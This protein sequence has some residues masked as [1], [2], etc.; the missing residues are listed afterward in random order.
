MSDF[1]GAVR[2]YEREIPGALPLQWHFFQTIESTRWLPH[3]LERGLTDEPLAAIDGAGTKQFREWPVGQY[4]FRIAKGTDADAQRL[5]ATAVGKVAQSKHPDGRHQGLD[6]IANHFG[7]SAPDDYTHMTPHPLSNSQMAT[8]SI[9]DALVI[10]VRDAALAVCAKDA[11]DVVGAVNLLR[12]FPAKIFTRISM[13]VLSKHANAAPELS[14]ALLLDTNLIGESWCEDEYSELALARF[15][16]LMGGE[17]ERI[18]EIIDAYPDEYRAAWAERF[19][20]HEKRPPGKADIR[21]FDLCVVRD[22]VWKWRQALPKQRREEIEEVGRE[23]GDPDDW[24]NRLFPEEV[25]PLTGSDFTSQP[26]ASVIIFLNA[27]KPE[28]GPARHTMSALGQQLR[29][30]VET[31]PLRFMEVAAQFDSLPPI[32]L[33]SILTAF[34]TYV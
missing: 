2:L 15:P 1:G 13:H 5:V 27:W 22:A 31:E 11:E 8:Y 14:A 18:L 6:I 33:R 26:I 32:Y 20:S 16:T 23:F 29:S 28:A 30:A 21:A 34:N 9:S 10:A 12:E 3:L 17:Q 19:E 24:K 4:L 25:S 7:D